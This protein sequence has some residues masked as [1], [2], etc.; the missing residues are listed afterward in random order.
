[1][2]FF[3]LG[4]EYMC[5]EILFEVWRTPT[6]R[7]ESSSNRDSMGCSSSNIGRN[8][9]RQTVQNTNQRKCFNKQM[10]TST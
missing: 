4:Q 1:M 3:I 10:L 5:I 7:D 6:F 2:D 8:G 9:R